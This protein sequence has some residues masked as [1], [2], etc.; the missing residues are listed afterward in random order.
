MIEEWRDVKGYEGLYQVS[1]LGR[2][3]SLDVDR[4]VTI[5]RKGSASVKE[6]WHSKG[7]VLK[8]IRPGTGNTLY[9]HLYDM[10]HS[11]VSVPVK[12]IV[13]EAFLGIDDSVSTS[14]IHLVHASKPPFVQNIVIVQ[15]L[16]S[17]TQLVTSLSYK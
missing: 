11:R 6:Y 1:N 16:S 13:A 14:N 10:D 3:R 9:V 8:Y 12:R 17:S 5:S 7:K 15:K 2:V 4:E